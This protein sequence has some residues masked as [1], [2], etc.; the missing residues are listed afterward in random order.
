MGEGWDGGGHRGHP[1]HLNPPPPRGEE[2]IFFDSIGVLLHGA[3]PLPPEGEGGATDFNRVMGWSQLKH[4][5][6]PTL[7]RLDLNVA[8]KNY[9]IGHPH[10]DPPP[11]DI[12]KSS[13]NN[14]S[15][16]YRKTMKTLPL[17]ED[18]AELWRGGGR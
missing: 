7:N 1:P 11:S 17:V 16:T 4:M 10:P 14:R 13:M 15:V 18:P 9:P 8:E 3:S 12:V 5:P 6:W 2:V